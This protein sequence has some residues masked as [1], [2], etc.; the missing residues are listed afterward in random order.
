[1]Y[2]VLSRVYLI[3]MYAQRYKDPLVY[4]NKAS[5]K[6]K[7]EKKSLKCLVSSKIVRTF[8]LANEKKTSQM[9]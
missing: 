3:N 2:F 6:K 5:K 4:T 1:M 7:N 9:H 8:A